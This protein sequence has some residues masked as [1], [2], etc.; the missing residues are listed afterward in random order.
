MK[1][2]QEHPEDSKACPQSLRHRG[3]LADA[4]TYCVFILVFLYIINWPVFYHSQINNYLWLSEGENREKVRTQVYARGSWGCQA[5]GLAKGTSPATVDRV[6]NRSIFRQTENAL[7][8][9]GSSWN[10]HSQKTSGEAQ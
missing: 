3:T 8:E 5:K 6:L 1:D 9:L 2:R 4:Q 7:P 10:R